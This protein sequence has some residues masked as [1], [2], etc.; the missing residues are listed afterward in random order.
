MLSLQE[1][2]ENSSQK[3][4]SF[5]SFQ[6]TWKIMFDC[7]FYI[8]TYFCNWK[9][10]E[11]ATIISI[12]FSVIEKA[13]SDTLFWKC[14]VQG[15]DN[16]IIDIISFDIHIYGDG[17]AAV[18]LWVSHSPGKPRVAGSSFGYSSPSNEILGQGLISISP[19]SLMGC[20]TLNTHTL[21][22][23]CQNVTV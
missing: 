4:K 17:G 7:Y 11:N 23:W 16:I 5:N 20:K 22:R 6:K 21:W 9:S 10:E 1:G 3:G 2:V 18:V 13:T 12:F 15:R 19:W 8:K 14:P